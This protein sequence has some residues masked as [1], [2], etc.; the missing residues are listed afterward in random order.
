MLKFYYYKLDN[1]NLFNNLI[2]SFGLVYKVQNRI[3]KETRAVKAIKTD[4]LS[5]QEFESEINILKA[6]DH[7][8]I[9]KLHEVYLDNNFVYLVEEYCKGGDLF[10]Y[11]KMQRYFTEKKAAS[12]MYQLLSALNHLHN[13]KIVHRDIK[14]DN[15]VFIESKSNDIIIKLIDFG[16][17]IIKN[18]EPLTKELGTIY[19]IAPE[20]FNNNY[21]EKCDVWSA[22]VILYIMLCGNPPFK[23]VRDKEIKNK[24]LK[25]E[26]NF[27]RIN[28]NN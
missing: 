14:P 12:I 13:K 6:V 26:F 27:N 24:I 3:T 8:N 28:I 9:I 22:G 25:G 7:P 15:I 4:E 5:E 2:G 16:T 1:I 10:D 11:I 19:Y 20:V 21:D 18:Q 23:G 17:S